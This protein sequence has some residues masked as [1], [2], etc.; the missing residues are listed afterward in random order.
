MAKNS[1]AKLY[2][3][4]KN[5]KRFFRC[6]SKNKRIKKEGKISPLF[7]PL[8]RTRKHSQNRLR[9]QASEGRAG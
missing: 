6:R 7:T 1:V 4:S 8:F 2:N 9:K 3:F 5:T